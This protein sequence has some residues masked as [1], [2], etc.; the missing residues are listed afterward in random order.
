MLAANVWHWW[1][2]AALALLGGGAVLGLVAG[3]IKQVVAP[4][5]PSRR[6]RQVL[7]AQERESL[8]SQ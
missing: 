2:G 1:I 4:Q 7:E 6:Q 3:Y 8:N 5:H